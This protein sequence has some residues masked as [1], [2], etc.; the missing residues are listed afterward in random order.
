MRKLND[1][2]LAPKLNDDGTVTYWSTFERAWKE[3]ARTVP[4]VE[5]WHMPLSEREVIRTH[6]SLFSSTR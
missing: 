6:L 1:D 2:P 5:F 3:N 4:E